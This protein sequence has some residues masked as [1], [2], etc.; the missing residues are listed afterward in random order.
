MNKIG[1]IVII[2]I[3]CGLGLAV[4]QPWVKQEAV[5]P[6]PAPVPA[7]PPPTPAPVP[8][9]PPPAPA[10]PAPEPQPAVVAPA[11]APEPAPAPAP[12]PAAQEPAKPSK[13]NAE[14]LGGTKWKAKDPKTPDFEFTRDGKW[15]VKDRVAS[16]WSFEGNRI[17][18]YDDKGEEH[19]ID[20]VGDKLM[21]GGEEIATQK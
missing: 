11:P 12:E 15:K 17:R 8:P 20:V 19:F 2:L 4:W 18:L 6:A 21:F 7:P 3:A 9:P 1:W 13:W 5:T 16:K 10:P 14:T